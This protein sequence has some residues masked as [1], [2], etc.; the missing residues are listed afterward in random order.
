MGQ[1]EVYDVLKKNKKEWL[2]VR[3]IS[4]KIPNIN[5]ETIGTS[6]SKLARS[7]L[8]HVKQKKIIISSKKNKR[9][10]NFYQYKE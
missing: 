1:Q 8:V 6:C 10:V 4:N 3:D 2:C 5:C 7:K 9:L